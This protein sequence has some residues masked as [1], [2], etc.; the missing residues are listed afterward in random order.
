MMDNKVDKELFQQYLSEA[1]TWETDKVKALASSKRT[2]WIIASVSAVLAI[3]SILAVMALTPLKSVEPYVIRV[4]NST[5]VVDVVQSI[6]DGKTNYEESINKFFVQWYL[7]YREG[8][9]K[10]LAEEY[11]YNVGLMSV[12]AEQQRYLEFFNPK[13]S[14]SP[15]NIYGDYA[16][17]KIRIKST[18][19]IKPDVALVR[20]IKEV[21]RGNDKPQTTHWAATVTFKYSTSPMSEKDRGINPLGFQV[22]EYRNDPDAVIQDATSP[23]SAVQPPSSTSS[24]VSVFPTQIPSPSLTTPSSQ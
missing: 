18:S 10:D 1:R 23:R 14:Q 8:Y 16:R 2:A 20:Y 6:K 21:E 5:G 11:Y 13:N 17:V 4:D 12:G 7:R 3:L 9:S 22:I 15:L 19:F 24:G